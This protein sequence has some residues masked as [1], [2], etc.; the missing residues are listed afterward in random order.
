M[1][2][3]VIYCNPYDA[4]KTGTLVTFVINS[5]NYVKKTF[6]VYNIVGDVFTP[7]LLTTDQVDLPGVETVY[8]TIE[9]IKGQIAACKQIVF[10]F[11]RYWAGFGNYV[12]RF[13]DK[14]FLGQG[15]SNS[16][17]TFNKKLNDK[18]VLIITS[19]QFSQ[20]F[21]ISN[22]DGLNFSNSFTFSILKLCGIRN[23]NWVNTN[24]RNKRVRKKIDN[25]FEKARQL[26]QTL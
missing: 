20:L 7:H 2:T 25:K 18:S 8:N 15:E 12:K 19:L 21:S 5:L 13:M 23:I 11:P 10:V 4:N 6:V 22:V 16:I 24:Q 14:V 17:F 9:K 26:L 3:I 1:D